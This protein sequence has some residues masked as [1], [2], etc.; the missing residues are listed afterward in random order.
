MSE[1]ATSSTDTAEDGGNGA[2]EQS[3][4]A[5]TRAT[6]TD[7]ETETST[8]ADDQSSSP[9]TPPDMEEHGIETIPPGRR[10]F[11]TISKN[12]SISLN[13]TARRKYCDDTTAYLMLGVNE[14]N[15]YIQPHPPETDALEQYLYKMPDGD[16]GVTLSASSFLKHF[17]VE[18]EETRRY[19]TEKNEDLEAI[20][21]DLDQ[22]GERPSSAQSTT[23]GQDIEKTT[24]SQ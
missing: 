9:E 14:N 11:V 7:T 5:E 18:H 15:L 19:R 20:C 2:T 8:A 17:R 6:S 10:P 21:V 23:G 24:D 22:E 12:G 13:A 4:G 16:G 3:T 1:S